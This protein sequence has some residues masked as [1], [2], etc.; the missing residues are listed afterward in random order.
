MGVIGRDAGWDC[1]VHVCSDFTCT[2]VSLPTSSKSKLVLVKPVEI[3]QDRKKSC[4]SSRA[5]LTLVFSKVSSD[6]N[7]H[8]LVFHGGP[9]VQQIT[10][11]V[12]RLSTCLIRPHEC[13]VL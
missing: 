3:L 6:H 7:G 4:W 1:V 8:L 13:V 12:M 2:D 11:K 10:D 9:H 5:A